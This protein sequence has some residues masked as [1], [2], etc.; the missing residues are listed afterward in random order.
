MADAKTLT[1]S[2]RKLRAQAAA[3]A[4]WAATPDRTSR[5]SR[6]RAAFMARF[7]DEVDPERTMTPTARAQAAESAREAHFSRMA[8]RSARA[9][10][11]SQLNN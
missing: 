3:H 9:R 10:R 4:S 1:R 8:Y 6:G 2:E 11:K 5:T 7:E